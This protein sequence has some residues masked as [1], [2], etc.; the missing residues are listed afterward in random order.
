MQWQEDSVPQAVM[1]LGTL[2]SLYTDKKK[3]PPSHLEGEA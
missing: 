3:K 2:S 1:R